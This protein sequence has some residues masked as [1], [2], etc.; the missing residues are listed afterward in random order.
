MSAE[1]LAE[2]YEQLNF[3]SAS[4]FRK[5]LA[6][7]GIKAAAKDVDEFV[8]SRTERQVIAPPPK[9]T[10]HI[11]AFDV[12][13]RWMA[14]V[15]S[16][17][18]R[19]VK[20]NEGVYKHILVIEDVFSRYVFKRPLTSTSEVT[21]AFEEILKES[22]DRMVDAD[23]YPRQLDTDGGSEW[24]NGGFK[25]LMARYKID[26]VVKDPDD[27]NA[28]ST[29]DRAISTIKRAIARRQA[30]KGGSWLS[31]LDAA[32][33][34]Y[35]KSEHSAIH[36]VPKDM[37]DDVIFALKKQAA[38]DLDQNTSMIQKR[39][40]KLTKA[41]GYRVHIPN[42]EG[43]KQR[44]DAQT[45]SADIRDVVSFPAPGVVQDSD[46]NRTLTKLARPVPR[47]SSAVAPARVPQPPTPLEPYA[48]SLRNFLG[49]G[50]TY[51]QA[52]KEM[53]RRDPAFPAT[54][55]ESRLSFKDFV[56]SFPQLLRI[57][58]GRI[59]PVGIN[60]LR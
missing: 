23:P 28:I 55:K 10:G 37:T 7:Q 6:K 39:Q 13:H 9:Y 48:R 49:P 35:N 1:Q 32:V 53:K 30:S 42:K 47:D 5:A 3:P 19:P 40:E 60:T 58:E 44:T 45:W 12:N 36:S 59:L 54:L 34:G 25:A 17:T 38:E 8:A 11:V 41:G 4:V 21:G 14:D 18:S 16:F 51:G 26:H 56:A 15:I 24:T 22:E 2:I 52:A 33:D 20:T 46:G 57:H 27:R 31:Q 50:K 43:L 29:V